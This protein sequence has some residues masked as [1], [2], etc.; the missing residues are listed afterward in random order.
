MIP[1]EIVS[2]SPTYWHQEILRR[3]VF[4]LGDWASRRAQ[5]VTIGQAPLEIRRMVISPEVSDFRISYPETRSEERRVGKE[6]R[7]RWS[8]YH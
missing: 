8:P 1:R 4:A 6:C 3:I 5:P 7:S 2:P